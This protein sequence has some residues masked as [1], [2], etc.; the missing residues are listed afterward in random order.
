MDSGCDDE[1]TYNDERPSMELDFHKKNKTKNS[2]S[3]TPIY[4]NVILCSKQ[5]RK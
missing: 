2:I 1:K 4:V 3:Y 5:S